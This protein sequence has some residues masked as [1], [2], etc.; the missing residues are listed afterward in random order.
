MTRQAKTLIRRLAMSDMVAGRWML[1]TGALWW[2]IFLAWPGALF[3]T[4][5]QIANGT[6]RTTYALMATFPEWLWATLFMLHGMFL[7]TSIFIK[8]PPAAALLDAFNGML[9]W[10][11]ATAA[12]YVSHF[13][14][15]ETYQPPAAMGADLAMAMGSIWWFIRVCADKD[16][17]AAH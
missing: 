5:E 12:C 11:C 2:G 8:V 3:P 4:V 6:G 9:L 17:E 1:G 15:W 7:I 10:V 14:G 13:H 16:Y